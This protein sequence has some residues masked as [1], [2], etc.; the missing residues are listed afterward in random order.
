MDHLP[1]LSDVVLFSKAEAVRNYA[2]MPFEPKIESYMADYIV[3]RVADAVAAEPYGDK[4]TLKRMGEMDVPDR[5]T[6]F[7]YGIINSSLAHNTNS[8][9][10]L[11]SQGKTQAVGINDKEHVDVITR[12]PGSQVPRCTALTFEL[13]DALEKDSYMAFDDGLGYLTSSP[14]MLGTGL[15]CRLL[16]HLPGLEQAKKIDSVKRGLE[17]YDVRLDALSIPMAG[18]SLYTMTNAHT[19]GADEQ[20]IAD[21]LDRCA[22]NVTEE[23]RDARFSLSSGAGLVTRDRLMRSVGIIKYCE[24][25]NNFEGIKHLMNLRHAACMGYIDVPVT[26]IDVLYDTIQPN[27]LTSRSGRKLN[28]GEMQVK[29]AQLLKSELRDYI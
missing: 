25:M 28:V 6:L 20:D 14:D 23:E 15:R 7:E 18:M 2:D 26:L 29:V 12:L 13:I 27:T 3:Q 19:I 5:L 8:G 10:A 21:S 24:L 1:P 22:V 4:F 17:E 11:I 9:A 16:V